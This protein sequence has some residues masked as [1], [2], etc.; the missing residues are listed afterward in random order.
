MSLGLP[1]YAFDVDYNRE[2]T[3]NDAA[4]FSSSA[5]LARMLAQVDESLRID[6]GKRMA[7]IAAR[8]YRWDLVAGQ[9]AELLG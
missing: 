8:R 6:M 3:E 4:Y 2:T 7:D 5:E 9:Y 1:V